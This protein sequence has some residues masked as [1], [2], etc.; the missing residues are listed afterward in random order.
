MKQLFCSLNMFVSDVFKNLV[1][2]VK[3]KHMFMLFLY[4]RMQSYVFLSC[5]SEINSI[6][7][8]IYYLIVED[9]TSQDT[10][11]L[12]VFFHC[13]VCGKHCHNF[14]GT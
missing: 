9:T 3:S 2:A 7:I 11:I 4:M 8:I 1:Y 13:S 10:F 12:W 5:I 6:N 14:A